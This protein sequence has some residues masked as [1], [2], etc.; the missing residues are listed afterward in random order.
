MRDAG[1][2]INRI[3]VAQQ[4]SQNIIKTF[5]DHKANY[6]VKVGTPYP[7]YVDHLIANYEGIQIVGLDTHVAFVVIQNGEL[8]Y[9]HASAGPD[10]CVVDENKDSATSLRHSNYR[11]ISNISRNADVIKRWILGDSFPTGGVT[12]NIQ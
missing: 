1:F 3:R 11:V 5:V 6:E 7:N 2:D 8:R 12:A 10:K 9:I 4:P